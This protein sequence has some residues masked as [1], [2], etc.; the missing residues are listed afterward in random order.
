MP[1]AGRQAAEQAGARRVLVEVKGLRIELG[2][3]RLDAIGGDR[4]GPGPKP[5][6]HREVLEEALRLNVHG[7]P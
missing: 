2:G 3:E 6:F 1:A 5:L 7:H 4:G